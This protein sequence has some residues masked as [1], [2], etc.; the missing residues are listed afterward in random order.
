MNQPLG[1]RCHLH[2]NATAVGTCIRCGAYLC[3]SCVRPGAAGVICGPC[4]GQGAGLEAV[5]WEQSDRNWLVR[6][7]KTAAQVWKEPL[8]GL[9]T[10]AK[11][12]NTGLPPGPTDKALS[13]LGVLL[14]VMLPYH[15]YSATI[16]LSRVDGPPTAHALV[17]L[18]VLTEAAVRL[19][20][21]TAL[22]AVIFHGIASVSRGQGKFSD[23]LRPIAY[24][25][26]WQLWTVPVSLLVAL[27][28]PM[29]LFLVQ[30]ILGVVLMVTF[31]A[32]MYRAGTGAY[33]LG[34]GVALIGAVVSFVAHA[35]LTGLA[36]RLGA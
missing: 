2:S 3:T 20:L 10:G 14:L 1:A 23:A 5:P 17:V 29:P 19:F 36:N 24:W 6:F 16:F 30:G 25:Q 34:P 35:L 21:G 12:S 31:V 13:F 33:R 11:R 22:G 27:Q 26:S 32:R 9:E 4:E 7:A 18:G 8:A 28:V 15:A